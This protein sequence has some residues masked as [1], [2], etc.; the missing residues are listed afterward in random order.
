MLRCH[1]EDWIPVERWNG[2]IIERYLQKGLLQS[3]IGWPLFDNRCRF[4]SFLPSAQT[5]RAT[6]A[7]L[8]IN[9]QRDAIRITLWGLE[10]LE[11]DSGQPSEAAVPMQQNR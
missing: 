1:I 2:L 8:R 3:R 7:D 9:A 11:G 10:E 4:P 6:L 5:I